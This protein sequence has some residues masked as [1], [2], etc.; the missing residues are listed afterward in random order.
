MKVEYIQKGALN[1]ALVSEVY[2][3]KEMVKIKQEI[4]ALRAKSRKNSTGPAKDPHGR[5][6]N[7]A[8][9]LWVDEHYEDRNKS[10]ILTLNRKLFTSDIAE[11]LLEQNSLYAHIRHC[12]SD[13]T[14]LN[15]YVNGTQYKAHRDSSIFTAIT[16]FSIGDFEGG[17]LEFVDYGV[18]IPPVENTMVI[19]AGCIKHEARPVKTDGEFSYRA[20][21]AQFMSYRKDC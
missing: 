2:T 10:S 20:S 11:Q 17:E 16:F 4:V 7:F 18:V 19:F 13:F 21:M 9:S 12:D 3:E 15:Y 1:Y 5:S 6:L 14:L 8:D